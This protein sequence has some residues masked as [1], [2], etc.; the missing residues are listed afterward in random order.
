MRTNTFGAIAKLGGNMDTNLSI[1]QKGTRLA[2]L[3]L[4]TLLTQ[5]EGQGTMTFTF[6]GQPPGTQ[7]STSLYAESG[8]DFWNPYG[9]QGPV[10]TGAGISGLPQNGTGY[11]DMPNTAF[12]TFSFNASPGTYFT[13]LSFDAAK[14][15]PSLSAT[16]LEVVGYR[17]MLGTVT[18][19]FALDTL[20]DRRT[21]N[22]PDFQTFQLG[23]EF[24][25][26]SRVDFLADRW[27][28]DNVVISGV[29]EPLPSELG[30]VALL[31]GLAKRRITAR[32][33]N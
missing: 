32:R 19:Y 15:Y 6:N 33:T 23:P 30:F 16:N 28:L 22:L 26:V 10:P 11:L 29:P 13:F 8:M 31:C 2:V 27:C 25:Q 1:T 9:P 4:T 3:L 14:E 20:A 24:Q 21:N 17:G 18:N 7:A 12:V 5:V